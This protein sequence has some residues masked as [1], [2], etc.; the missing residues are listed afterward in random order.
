MADST[1]PN[2]KFNSLV[3]ITGASRGIGRAIAIAIA[4]EVKEAS[5]N[6][7]T[8]VA[9]LTPPLHLVLVARSAALLLETASLVDERSGGCKSEKT[10]PLSIVTSCH[11]M[12]LSDLDSLPE[13]L[14]QVLEPLASEDYDLCWL[15]NNAGSL[16]PLGM[17]SSLCQRGA[18]SSP[19]S[20]LKE[21]RNAIDL[22]VTS[23]MWIS[24]Q[25]TETFLPPAS[26]SLPSKVR[27]V[28]VVNMSSLCAVE[29]FPTMAVYCAGKSARDMFHSVLAKEHS[30]KLQTISTERN[31]ENDEKLNESI[32]DSS[33]NF[34]NSTTQRVPFKVLNY[35]PGACDTQMIDILAECPI[36][37]DGLHQ[38]YTSFK[39]ENRLILPEET[40]KKLIEFLN[41]DE[42][43][44]GSHVD[45]WDI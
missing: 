19:S 18:S 45:Y 27:L 23:A 37:N 25:F 40:A 24:S 29:P 33:A 13:K 38:Y 6:R 10:V 32:N 34:F 15:I 14:N 4:D 21:L 41:R 11:E 31:D 9:M 22:N 8:A 7:P 36:L 26:T 44:S 17:T 20:A 3:V 5:C 12:D 42:F 1:A 28:R 39:K 30:S 2:N 43:E 35:A 16:G